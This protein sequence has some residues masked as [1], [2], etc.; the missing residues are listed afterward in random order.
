ME[1]PAHLSFD[2]Q[3]DLLISR[4]IVVKDGSREIAISR[5]KDIGYYKI[6]SFS[7][8]LS[9]VDRDKNRVYENVTF[10]DILNRFYA[11]K[12]LRISLLHS[13]EDIEV[14]IK[15]K[16]AHILGK[17]GAYYYLKFSNW[18]N[19]EEYCKYYLDDKESYFKNK[20][21]GRV[22]RSDSIEIKEKRNLKDNKYPTIWLLV[23]ILTF[24]DITELLELM[25]QKNL[26]ILANYYNCTP[27]QLKSWLKSLKFIRNNC[28]H[29]S[30]VID[31][32][33]KTKPIILPDWKINLFTNQKNEVTRRLAVTL[34][35]I[36][37][38]MISINPDYNFG[39]IYGAV[40]LLITNAT[41]REK[42]ANLIGFAN[43]ESFYNLFPRKKKKFKKRKKD[44]LHIKS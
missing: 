7:L 23:E 1:E 17:N 30:T 3:L 13:I 6:K 33:I 12:D 4:G 32:Q 37:E 41:D 15:T 8:P 27:D 39:K 18:C 2:E 29:N 5:L 20:I 19:K 24:G 34:C 43:E 44:I 31:I 10:Q 9:R 14:S 22:K 26:K 42:A 35:I 38:M 16:I 28:A 21:V 36:K 11:D 25:S 40:N